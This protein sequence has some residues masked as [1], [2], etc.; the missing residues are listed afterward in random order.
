MEN[1]FQEFV[2]DPRLSR[3]IEGLKRSN[4]I[5]NIIDP[6]ENQHSDILKWLFDP[7]EGHGQGDAIFKDFLTSAY[8]NSYENV[9]SNKD[10]FAEW[11]PSR[12]AR[13]GFHSLICIREYRLS[14]GG[15]LD[16]LMVDTVNRILVVVEN[17]HGARLGKTQLTD[18][19]E[20]V[21][22]LRKRPAFNGYLTAHIV[23][24]RNYGGAVDEAGNR[25]APRNRWAFLDYQ[26]LEAGAH[27]AELQ[28][29]RGNQSA[30]LVIAYCQKQT[31]YVQPEEKE[32]DDVLADVARDY[33]QVVSALGSA[34]E[35]DVVE[36]TKGGLGGHAGELW[37]FANH[38]PELIGRLQTKAELS[39]IESRLRTNLPSRKFVMSYGK[40]SFWVFN[41]SWLCFADDNYKH[42]PVCIHGWDMRKQARGEDK[43]AIGVQY[44]PLNLSE[45]SRVTVQ[46]ALEREFP[47]LTKGRQNAS[48]RMLGKIAEVSESAIATKAQ[49]VYVRLEAALAPLVSEIL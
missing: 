28:L 6:N 48:F 21:A 47:E 25:K 46:D 3:V 27:R 7:R 40:N 34:L 23:L 19:Y 9:L 5:F 15:R 26:W 31:D 24:D 49:E 22:S 2:S 39:F 37:I 38:H 42:W 13:T 12:I 43:F 35:K 18:Y 14:N 45:L 16:L 11:T 20:E 1:A 10:F 8:G 44:R 41:E 29:K 32:V 33:R 30:G 36:L 17:K 4:D